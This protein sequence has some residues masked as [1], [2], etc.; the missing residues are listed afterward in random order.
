MTKNNKIN[1]NKLKDVYIHHR[2]LLNR[3]AIEIGAFT[4]S[5]WTTVSLT[6]LFT[7][8]RSYVPL[9]FAVLLI[10]QYIIGRF[11]YGTQLLSRD[12]KWHTSNDPNISAI[13]ASLYIIY[14][15]IHLIEKE[16]QWVDK[17]HRR[18]QRGRRRLTSRK[19]KGRK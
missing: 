12:Y 8:P 18:M 13:F 10:M 3:G 14:E 6:V 19:Y 9:C 15:K 5:I 1:W 7:I 4:G 17:K 11:Y 2:N 16:L